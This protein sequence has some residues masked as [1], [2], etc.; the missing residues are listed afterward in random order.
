MH[1][2][3]DF[4]PGILFTII[5]YKL[6]F[7]YSHDIHLQIWSYGTQ[8]VRCEDEG[9]EGIKAVSSVDVDSSQ[10]A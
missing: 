8:K 6:R 10:L 3:L 4:M 1:D 9:C 7:S 5:Y 2:Q